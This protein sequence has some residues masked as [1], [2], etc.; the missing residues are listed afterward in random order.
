MDRVEFG[1]RLREERQR[2]QL[3]TQQLAELGRVARVSQSHYETGRSLPDAEY[4]SA[5]HMAGVDIGYLLTGSR[6]ALQPFDWTLHNE[7]LRG[8]EA[9]L[10]E[11]D[12]TL[13]FD[14]KM[15]VLQVLMERFS[16]RG[17]APDTSTMAQI[18]RIAA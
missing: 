12:M 7:I 4:L 9:W 14:K 16:D 5:A 15:Q 13:P 18:L 6:F 11:N 1:L 2:L 10:D 8:I 17:V 3:S